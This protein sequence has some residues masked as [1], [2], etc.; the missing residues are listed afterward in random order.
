M[1]DVQHIDHIGIRIS[2]RAVSTAFYEKLGFATVTDAGFDEGH[3]IIMRHPSG[4]TL[5]LLGPSTAGEGTNILMDVSDK[6]PG[7]THF[8]LHVRSLDDTKAF[9][10]R[11]GIA[12]TGSFSFGP[13]S[14][15]FIRD[16]DRTVIEL[17]ARVEA[18]DKS[19]SYSDHP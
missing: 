4:V 2:D 3:P 9:L 16:P 6:H 17:D 1:L 15:V 8:A 13:L 5:N 11:E 10:A 19:G 12:I 14:A 7:I 18:A